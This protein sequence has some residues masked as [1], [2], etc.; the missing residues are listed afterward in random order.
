MLSRYRGSSPLSPPSPVEVLR[1]SFGRVVLLHNGIIENH[2]ELVEKFGLK[3]KLKT[4][5]DTE[6]A[7]AVFDAYY[8]GNPKEA[9]RKAVKEFI[10][11]YAFCIMFV[12]QG[13]AGTDI[14]CL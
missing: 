2:R 3:G 8:Q 1:Y 6:I 10:G 13:S 7:A 14:A 12:V 4:Q 9:I 5:T 11:T